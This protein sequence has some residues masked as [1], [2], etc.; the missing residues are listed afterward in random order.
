MKVT[1]SLFVEDEV[2]VIDSF[3]SGF[4]LAFDG[5]SGLIIHLTDEQAEKLARELGFV[6]WARDVDRSAA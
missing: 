1:G 6:L 3:A 4:A 5:S 2:S